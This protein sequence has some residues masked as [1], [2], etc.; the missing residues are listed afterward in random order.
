MDPAEGAVPFD[1]VRSSRYSGHDL[2][3]F[4]V[5]RAD[6]TGIRSLSRRRKSTT[7]RWHS[8][9]L[10]R[11]ILWTIDPAPGAPRNCHTTRRCVDSSGPLADL[12]PV[13]RR[14]SGVARSLSFRS[15]L[16][17]YRPV[18][19]HLTL[20]SSAG[21]VHGVGRLKGQPLV[22]IVPDGGE[23]IVEGEELLPRC[24]VT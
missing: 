24:P 5:F 12:N 8:T 10:Y 4:R 23:E 17:P 19:P 9:C 13:G 3:Q 14:L 7:S 20:I 6:K 11:M 16:R 18:K 2:L 21:T 1:S 15:V 22:T